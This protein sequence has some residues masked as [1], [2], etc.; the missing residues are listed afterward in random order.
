MFVIVN[1]EDGVLDRI[2]AERSAIQTEAGLAKR[3]SALMFLNASPIA[4]CP[5]LGET[6]ISGSGSLW[7]NQTGRAYVDTPH[8]NICSWWRPLCAMPH[9]TWRRLTKILFRFV[10]VD[11]SHVVRLKLFTLHTTPSCYGHET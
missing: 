10:V 7:I 4:R 8:V 3:V 1:R 9:P 2:H 11:V 5:M 6:I